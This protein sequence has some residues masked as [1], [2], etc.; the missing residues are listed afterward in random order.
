MHNIVGVFNSIASGM[1]LIEVAV[2]S[3]GSVQ[4]VLIE[5]DDDL[6]TL[7][8]QAAVGIAN[9]RLRHHSAHLSTEVQSEIE[10]AVRIR[11]A[12]AEDF[13]VRI[14]QRVAAAALNCDAVK[15]IGQIL[16]ETQ[17]DVFAGGTQTHI[18]QRNR[19]FVAI[20][21]R[22]VTAGASH[23]DGRIVEQPVVAGINLLPRVE[24]QCQF[25]GSHS[26]S[27]VRLEEVAD[28]RSHGHQSR[29]GQQGARFQRVFQ[30]SLSADR[31]TSLD[32]H[33][34]LVQAIANSSQP[35]RNQHCVNPEN[36]K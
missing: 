25:L 4:R 16:S 14:L 7:L 23:H 20:A 33:P 2:L 31:S 26:Q 28:V 1:Q 15:I 13:P 36:L 9:N 22:A 19:D 21:E 34:G 11:R 17:H 30:T 6:V 8:R 18:A 27:F 32:R 5:V 3:R 35:G 29:G 10:V 12:A 24:L